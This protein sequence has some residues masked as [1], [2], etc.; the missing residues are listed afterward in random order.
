M[1]EDVK[2]VSAGHFTSREFWKHP[3]I[4]IST[5]EFLYVTEGE[6]HI[7]EGQCEF[8][9]RAGDAM[10]LAP[11]VE[12][13]GVRKSRS[14]VS[15]IWIHISCDGKESIN[16]L[17]SL[18]KP[19]RSVQTTQIP[20]MAR[21]LLHRASHTIYSE[22]MLDMTAWLFV[23]EYAL[24]AQKRDIPSE[25]G[26]L[27]NRIR[28]WVKINSDKKLS[29]YSVAE[30]F[31]YNEDYITRLFKNKSGLPLKSFIDDMRMNFLRA[32]LLTT[33]KPLKQIALDSDFDDYKAFLK[34]FTYHEGATPTEFRKSCYMTHTNNK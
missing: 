32:Q 34:F 19:L 14:R 10:L 12:H 31:G 25:S 11:G 29:V 24:F 17:S 5:W 4:K 8:S 20:M 33:D 16:Y 1:L 28:E 22:D 15:F 26:E 9:L 27:V 2:F 13:G 7:Y 18:A 21:Q 3:V 30:K 23:M 6:V